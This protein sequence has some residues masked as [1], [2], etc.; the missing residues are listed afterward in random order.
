MYTDF[1]SN[2]LSSDPYLISHLTLET[3][4]YRAPAALSTVEP[5]E[6]CPI[7]TVLDGEAS[8]IIKLPEFASF[9]EPSFYWEIV[10][11]GSVA[12]QVGIN[13]ESFTLWI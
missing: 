2:I 7:W 6:T 1:N 13:V 8:L 12:S 4:P 3:L 5:S 10:S 11:S 9:K